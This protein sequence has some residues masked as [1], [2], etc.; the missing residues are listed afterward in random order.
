MS[1]ECFLV[2]ISVFFWFMM[3]LK[4]TV[5]LDQL[6]CGSFFSLDREA[7]HHVILLE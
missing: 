7:L 3:A 5:T 1:E 6:C 2:Y 4:F